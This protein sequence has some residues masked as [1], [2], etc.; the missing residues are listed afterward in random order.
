VATWVPLGSTPSPGAAQEAAAP[1]AV[2]A[3]ASPAGGAAAPVGG[4]TAPLTAQAP[5]PKAGTLSEA[6]GLLEAGRLDEA[7]GG[8]LANLR[9][10]PVGSASVQLLVACSTE[11][12]QKAVASVGASELVIVPV[13]YK[14]RDCYRLCWGV[15]DSSAGAASAVRSVPDYFRRGGASPRVVSAAEILP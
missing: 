11:T 6:R 5:A 7:A 10:A 9:R 15:Y 4:T 8:F 1:A 12:V 3:A 14:G 2:G 13:N